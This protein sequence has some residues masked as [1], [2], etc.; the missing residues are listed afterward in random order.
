MDQQI[1]IGKLVDLRIRL[2]DRITAA[3]KASKETTSLDKER[4]AKLDAMLLKALLDTNQESAR[5]DAGTVYKNPKE[6][7]TVADREVFLNWVRENDMW[8]MLPS[9]VNSADVREY[10]EENHGQL[11]P[12]IKYSCFVTVGVRRPT[13][14]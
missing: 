6:S 11:P 14:K 7:F 10:K 8:H 3:E 5:T 4:L 1:D 13:N 2:K 12:G 9:S